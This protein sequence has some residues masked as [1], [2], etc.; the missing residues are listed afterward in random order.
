MKSIWAIMSEYYGEGGG[1]VVRAYTDKLR[2][3]QDLQMLQKDSTKSWKMFEVLLVEGSGIVSEWSESY[4][5]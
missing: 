4:A 3:E 1:E 5:D 2:A